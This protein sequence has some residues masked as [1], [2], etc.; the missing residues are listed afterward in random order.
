MNRFTNN[1]NMF[2]NEHFFIK[3]R[4]KNFDVVGQRIES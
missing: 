2:I 4:T 3:C 1:N